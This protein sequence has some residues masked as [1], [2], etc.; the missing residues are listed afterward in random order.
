MVVADVLNP[1]GGQTTSNV[2]YYIYKFDQAV[3]EITPKSYHEA[4]WYINGRRKFIYAMN[5]DENS[6]V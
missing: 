6:K 2:M 4:I 3:P 1:K 5:L